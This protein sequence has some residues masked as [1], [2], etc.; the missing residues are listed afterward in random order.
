MHEGQSGKSID[1]VFANAFLK[2]YDPEWLR[3]FV[4]GKARFIG[5][6]G[7]SELQKKFPQ[8]LKNCLNAGSDTTL[9]VLADV[10]ELKNGEQ[11]KEQYWE[12]ARQN[13]ISEESF[14]NV[15]FIF[16]RKRIENWVQYLSTGVTDEGTVGPRD[17]NFSEAKDMAQKL[18]KKCR[19]P[20]QTKETLPKSLE[21]SCNNWKALV[22]RMR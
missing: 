1:P 20:Q 10:D 13:K 5:C 3:P 6:G 12:I 7:K 4:T 18:A 21:W 16:P 2:A 9:I 17:Y 19:Q 8:E 14:E 22:E 15:V 11:L